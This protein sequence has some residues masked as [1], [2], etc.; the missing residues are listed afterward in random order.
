MKK[1]KINITQAQL[2]NYTV[3]LKEGKPEVSA[4]IALLTKGGKP[5]T[6][7]SVQTDSWN[8]KDKIELPIEAMPLIGDLARILEGVV[9]RH[10][11]DSQKALPAPGQKVS[12]LPLETVPV[13]ND[14]V[15][16]EDI[17]DEP[18]SLDDIPF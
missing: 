18:I 16:I 17:S 14:E 13:P 3:Y 9:V 2:V 11:M 7:Y 10:C 8:D 4:S 12:D 5:I 1:L 6:T 15:V